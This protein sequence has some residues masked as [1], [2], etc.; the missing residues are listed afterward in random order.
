MKKKLVV[1]PE[2]KMQNLESQSQKKW[3]LGQSVFVE[4]FGKRP[5]WQEDVIVTLLG[6]RV[7]DV[8]TKR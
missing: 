7:V 6:H 5:G 8:Q 4:S 2:V 3:S 1:E